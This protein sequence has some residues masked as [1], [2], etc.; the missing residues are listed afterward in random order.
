[1]NKHLAASLALCLSLSVFVLAGCSNGTPSND[2][3]SASKTENGQ[4]SESPSTTS[5]NSSDKAKGDAS[6][7]QAANPNNSDSTAGSGSSSSTGSG[8]ASTSGNS[9]AD[10]S[11]Q[12]SSSAKP[13]AYGSKTDS[14]DFTILD[15]TPIKVSPADGFEN[16]GFTT[17]VCKKGGT[18][19][20]KASS[21]KLSWNVYVMDEPFDDAVRYIP[22]SCKPTTKANGSVT[23]D[24]G[25]YVYVECGVSAYSDDKAPSSPTL[26][27]SYE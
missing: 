12:A 19:A 16:R 14:D 6:S 24:K 21:P 27:I 18:Y 1:M 5:G 7:S 22:H 15:G 26:T 8:N 10:S 2:A 4:Q 13:Q 11:S 23:L 17:F 25:Q 3:S 20:F 9:P